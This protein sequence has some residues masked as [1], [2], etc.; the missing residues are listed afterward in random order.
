MPTCAGRNSQIYDCIFFLPFTTTHNIRTIARGRCGAILG[1]SLPNSRHFVDPG[2]LVRLA[3]GPEF[4]DGQNDLPLGQLSLQG[5]F[6]GC[7]R[8]HV[9][10]GG[11]SA[12]LA[13]RGHGF[14]VLLRDVG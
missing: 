14:F 2:E 12:V 13:R 9:F 10:H 3:P 11:G 8:L 5:L 6:K 7:G 1:R 4:F